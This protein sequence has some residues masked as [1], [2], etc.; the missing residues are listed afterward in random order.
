MSTSNV[1]S[2]GSYGCVHKP[3]LKCKGKRTPIKNKVSKVLYS[4]HAKT[5]LDEYKLV[6]NIDKKREFHLGKP[7]LCTVDNTP[8]NYSA[9]KQCKKGSE[10]LKNKDD[11]S[12]LI[13]NDGGENIEGFAEKMSKSGTS[14]MAHHFW[15]DVLNVLLGIEKLVDKGIVHHDLKPQNIVYKSDTRDMKMIDFGLMTTMRDINTYSEKNKYPFAILHWSFPF[16]LLFYNKIT[17]DNYAAK[18]ASAMQYYTNMMHKFQA[19]GNNDDSTIHLRTFFNYMQVNGYSSEYNRNLIKRYWKDFFTFIVNMDK[20][21]HESFVEMSSKTIDL[22]GLGIALATAFSETHKYLDATLKDRLANFIYSLTNPNLTLRLTPSIAVS[23]YTSILE[24][25]GVLAKYKTNVDVANAAPIPASI[26]NKINSIH[27]GDISM[28]PTEIQRVV[29]ETIAK[30]PPEKEMNPKTRRCNNRCKDGYIRNP[31][32]KCVKHIQHNRTEKACPPEKEMNPKTR[33]CNNKC[34]DGYIRNPDFKCVKHQTQHNRTMKKT[35]LQ[36][37]KTCPQ[38]KEM[39]PKT[40][41]C[42]NVC[43][44]GYVRDASFKCVRA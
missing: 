10:F 34:K 35:P 2:E 13:M 40:R 5:E 27:I 3:P 31:D 25:T 7:T 36:N 14:E 6:S 15:V 33:R 39:N 12:L 23:E 9:I 20:M 18:K 28:T 42:N 22:Y 24:N 29:N 11:L 26:R 17:Y 43:K 16:E 41:R 30:C 38:G 44:P 4:R 21:T 1:V 32:F 19:S 8:P 37:E